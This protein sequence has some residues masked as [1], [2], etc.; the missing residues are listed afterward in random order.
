MAVVLRKSE[1]ITTMDSGVRVK[2]GLDQGT[3]LIAKYG[4]VR[5]ING[6]NA[7]SVYRF[8]RLR[9]SD[10]VYSMKLW[11]ANV[12]PGGVGDAGGGVSNVSNCDL[13]LWD[14]PDAV[15]GAGLVVDLDYFVKWNLGGT[16]AGGVA[17]DGKEV[18]FKP[19]LNRPGADYSR[20]GKPIWENLGLAA[21]PHLPYDVALVVSTGSLATTDSHFAVMALIAAP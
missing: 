3:R 4:Y 12:D 5:G 13:G 21:D 8:L 10:I 18:A 14:V 7:N 1:A 11:S 9:S 15:G 16:S 20:I 17:L 6:D 2:A 19:G